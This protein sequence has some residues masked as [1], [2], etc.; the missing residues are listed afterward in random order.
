MR[1]MCNNMRKKGD[2]EFTSLLGWIIAI[3]IIVIFVIS[4][5]LMRNGGEN[6]I[7]KISSLFKFGR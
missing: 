7:E 1:N 3:A 2:V 4:Y 6:I 5:I